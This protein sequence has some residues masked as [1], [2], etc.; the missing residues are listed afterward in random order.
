MWFKCIRLPFRETTTFPSL[1]KRE[2]INHTDDF[3][4]ACHLFCPSTVER[5]GEIFWE[6][7]KEKKKKEEEQLKQPPH[8]VSLLRSRWVNQRF[9]PT[10]S[11]EITRSPPWL[12][13]THPA[14]SDVN[15]AVYFDL[16]L[17]SRGTDFTP[18]RLELRH[19]HNGQWV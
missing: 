6:K 17:G 10:E 5:C 4:A 8:V 15:S 3:S 12:L 16:F 13:G 14:M 1:N 11:A 7:K 2:A 9:P 19:S 18:L